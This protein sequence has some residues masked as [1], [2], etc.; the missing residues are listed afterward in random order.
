MTKR[1]HLLDYEDQP[2]H[3]IDCDDAYGQIPILLDDLAQQGFLTEPR[4]VQGTWEFA[5]EVSKKSTCGFLETRSS[6]L[7]FQVR[8]CRFRVV[9][10]FG[11]G[12]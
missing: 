12:S 4:I 7:G 11:L 3:H 1:I 6:R 5:G 2:H 9:R 8:A 10:V